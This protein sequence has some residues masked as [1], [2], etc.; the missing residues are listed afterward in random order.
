[1]V[2]R[3]DGCRG[4]GAGAGAGARPSAAAA[5]AGGGGV[6]AESALRGKL[7]AGEVYYVV[8]AEMQ[9]QHRWSSTTSALV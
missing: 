1:M 4:G 9:L 5:A 6:A 8:H 2:S 7:P 3:K